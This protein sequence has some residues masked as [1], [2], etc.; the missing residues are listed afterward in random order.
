M[1]GQEAGRATT[2]MQKFILGSEKDDLKP[3]PVVIGMSATI[4]R[5][6]MLVQNSSATIQQVR[7]STEEVRASGL[8]KDRVIIYY[9]KDASEQK[10]MAILQAATEEW[11][12]KCKHWET[13]CREQHHWMVRPIFVVQ[14]LNGANDNITETDL[15]ECLRNIEQKA[16]IQ[17]STGEVVHAFG[18]TKGAISVNGLDVPYEEPSKIQDNRLARVVFFKETL[19]TGWDCPRAETMMSFRRY[20]DATAIAQLLGR[21]VRTPIQQ[22]ILVDDM[23]NDVQLFLPHFDADKVQ[24][25]VDELQNSEGGDLPTDV[26]GDEIE[27]GAYTVLTTRPVS[28]RTPKTPVDDYP[29]LFDEANSGTT[30]IPNTGIEEPDDNPIEFEYEL[31]R[32]GIVKFIN[33]LALRSYQ[34]R[35]FQMSDYLKSLFEFSNF[36]LISGLDVMARDKVVDN[37]VER[38][39]N[40]IQQLKNSGKYAAAKEQVMNFEMLANVYD[41]FGEPIKSAVTGNLF[42]ESSVDLDRQVRIAD[43]QLRDEEVSKAYASK[44]GDE[45]NHI[46]EKV[47]VILFVCDENRM[48]ELVQWAEKEFN[49]LNDT[50]RQKTTKLSEALKTQYRNIVRNSAEV[51]NIPFNLGENIFFHN[52]EGGKEYDDHLF[53]DE[54]TGTVRIKLNGWEER[55]IAEEQKREDFRCWYRNPS[56]GKDALTLYHEYKGTPKPFYPDFLIIRRENGGDY[57]L[58][59]LE[60]H[61]P[62]RDDNVSKAKALA[63]YAADHPAIGRAQLIRVQKSS[64]GETL[65]RL[66][67]AA[68]SEL[69]TKVMSINLPDE[70]DNLFTQY[71][72]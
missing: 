24:Q 36:L 20:T 29:S 39:H 70:L 42:S 49:R 43:K 68:H 46:I 41:A 2:I 69:R 19:S 33:S 47:D 66:D 31:D 25:V 60:P 6:N 44:Y 17:F 52:D 11:V 65:K 54:I 8:L 45:N 35:N 57:I 7:V 21:M 9:P 61:D 32:S 23:L 37:I 40:Y 22:R 51:S 5:F 34:V 15:D 58:D 26:Y 27:H 30:T 64:I 48:T 50:Y 59:I 1:R 13:F 12:S 53:V 3:V 71:G 62:T 55:V 63:K 72:E 16:G 28:K 14:V 4:Q 18:D 38:I 67:F 10:D 56:K